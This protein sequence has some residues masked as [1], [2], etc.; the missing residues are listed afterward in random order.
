MGILDDFKKL[1][2]AKKAVAKSAAKKVGHEA[3]EMAEEGFE[4]V[5]DLSDK[6]ADKVG[7][8]FEDAKD[9]TS[10]LLDDWVKKEPA[11]GEKKPT[12]FTTSQQGSDPGAKDETLATKAKAAGGKVVDEAVK[13]SDKVWE[14]AEEVGGK[15]V[16]KAEDLGSKAKEMAKDLGERI[17]KKLDEMVEKAK[18]LDKK[19]EAERDAIDKDRDGFADTPVNEKLREQGSLLEDKDDFWSKAD[20]YAEGDY[21]MGKPQIVGKETPTRD[22]KLDLKPLPGF[23]DNDGDGDSLIDDADIVDDDDTEKDDGDDDNHDDEEN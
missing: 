14:K 6:V 1:F 11:P 8:A 15:A 10:E 12:G 18:D 13:M 3:K 16:E 2:W 5:K 22:D 17:D 9:Y 21:S 19:I 7:D 20:R 23:T 4:K